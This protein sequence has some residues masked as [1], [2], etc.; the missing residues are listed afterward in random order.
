MTSNSSVRAI[1]DV[2]VQLM[3]AVQQD[4]PVAFEELMMR[5]QGRV[6]SLL[7][8]VVGDLGLAEDITQEVFLRVFRARKTYQPSAKFVT[9]IFTIANNLAINAIRSRQRTQEKPFGGFSASASDPE[10][11]S[12]NPENMVLASSGTIPARRLDKLEMREMVHLAVSSLGDRQ[13]MALLL[14]Q[15][16]GLNYHDIAQ[17]MQLSPQGVKSLLCRARMSLRDVLQGYMQHGNKVQTNKKN[18]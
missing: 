2:D 10:M 18:E 12:W 6:C 1:H 13:R 5:Y 4:D 8:H 15:F 11:A 17:I 9:W 7:K 16:E 3:L 14:H